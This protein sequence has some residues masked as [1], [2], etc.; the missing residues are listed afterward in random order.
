M[1]LYIING[2]LFHHCTRLSGDYLDS[3]FNKRNQ[4]SYYYCM[5]C[6]IKIPDWLTIGFPIRNICE[7]EFITFTESNADTEY[8]KVDINTIKHEVIE[9]DY[10]PDK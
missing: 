3:L 5:S 8:Y 10:I 1:K 4:K 9:Y 7:K 6:D 2:G